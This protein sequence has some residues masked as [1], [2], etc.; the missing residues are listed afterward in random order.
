MTGTV[1]HCHPAGTGTREDQGT[2]TA[3]VHGEASGDS[4]APA[5]L[6]TAPGHSVPDKHHEFLFLS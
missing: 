6:P 2:E 5:A 4:S 1:G 3:S